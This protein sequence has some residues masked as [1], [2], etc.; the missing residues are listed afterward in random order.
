MEW[1]RRLAPERGDWSATELVER[2]FARPEL[3]AEAI[4]IVGPGATAWAIEVAERAV[5]QVRQHEHAS[6]YSTA[7]SGRTLQASE[8]SFLSLL[9][10]IARSGETPHTFTLGEDLVGVVT[11]SARQGLPLD[12]L[13]NRIWAI[14]TVTRDEI[15]GALQRVV[16]T[17]EQPA[18]LRAVSTA[19][20]D[21]VNAHT[22]R[23]SEAYAEELRAW[24]GR[25]TFEQHQIIEAVVGG[26]APPERAALDAH[27]SGSHLYA[28]GWLEMQSW[29]PDLDTALSDFAT[30]AATAI[31]A[32]RLVQLERDG[33]IQLWWSAPG[34]LIA[35]PETVLGSLDR[36][37]WLRLAVG[38]AGDGVE[39]FR[40]AV[41]GA[42]RM[43]RLAHLPQAADRSIW[44]FSDHGHLSLV[45]EDLDTAAWF[46]RRELGPL[47]GPGT[48]MS[49][50]RETVRLYLS[51]GNSRV[52]VAK[53]LHLAPNTV[54][55]RVGQANEL[56][57]R[58]VGERAQQVLLALQLAEVLPGLL[59]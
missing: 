7:T 22:H 34:A 52:T 3:V 43:E 26:A 56:L 41:R 46:V 57:G 42:R 59:D 14:H 10:A 24:R 28:I 13:L 20:F 45:T 23:V 1:V 53:A 47:A 21:Y 6:Q 18:T 27:W 30:R 8:T 58:P 12:V 35:E 17:E 11:A 50:I 19:M 38:P 32:D 55:Y 40:D 39:G 2:S 16:P 25:R 44:H 15:F 29:V 54:A 33:V 5:E 36:P 4:D 37:D 49:E 48:R 9:I 31:H 51:T